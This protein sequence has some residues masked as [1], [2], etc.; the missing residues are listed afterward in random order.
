MLCWQWQQQKWRT[1]STLTLVARS[2]LSHDLPDH[3]TPHTSHTHAHTP[4]RTQ[5]GR[6]QAD[7]AG[8]ILGVEK[9]M[10]S[11]LRVEGAALLL[12]PPPL[13]HRPADH[14]PSLASRAGHCCRWSCAS[15]TACVCA[16]AY[17]AS[18]IVVSPWVWLPRSAS[19][20]PLSAW[21]ASMEQTTHPSAAPLHPPA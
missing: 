4:V 20:V 3:T 7:D 16:R 6:A 9:A 5:A 18:A 11:L 10:H 19:L 15:H 1:S 13:L 12:Q 14:H 17:V 8:G 21:P 2:K